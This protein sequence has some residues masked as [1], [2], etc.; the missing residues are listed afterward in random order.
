MRRRGP[1][2]LARALLEACLAHDSDRESILGDLEE[3]YESFIA[4]TRAE[5]SAR[6]W[7]WNQVACSLGP[8]LI[9]SLAKSGA[10]QG[11][12]AGLRAWLVVVLTFAFLT[13]GSVLLFRTIAAPEPAR[14]LAYLSVGFAS[15]A[16]GGLMAWRHRRR[17]AFVTMTLGT[18]CV[19]MVAMLFVASP[20]HESPAAWVIWSTTMFAGVLTGRRLRSGHVKDL[21]R[22]SR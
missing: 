3:E 12:V 17:D 13:A 5:R 20:E 21:P 10:P 11:I 19:A 6:R 22:A 8:V 15:S 4:P 16:L 9:Q 14:I 18:M 1:P 7:Y 2:A